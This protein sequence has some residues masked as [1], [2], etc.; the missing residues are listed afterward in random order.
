LC[1]L[2]AITPIATL[3]EDDT[4]N[5]ALFQDILGA[6]VACKVVKHVDALSNLQKSGKKVWKFSLPLKIVLAQ[7][8]SI[9]F[10]TQSCTPPLHHFTL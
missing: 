3:N 2:Q 1:N 5:V 7:S 8:S 9:D 6:Q 10:H 4:H